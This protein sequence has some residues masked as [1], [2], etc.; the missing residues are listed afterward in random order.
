MNA[1]PQLQM[2]LQPI[3][4]PWFIVLPFPHLQQLGSL[5][6]KECRELLEK[7]YF[8]TIHHI[9]TRSLRLHVSPL[10]STCPLWHFSGVCLSLSHG[11]MRPRSKLLCLYSIRVGLVESSRTTTSYSCP[12]SE[13]TIVYVM[14]LL[15][16][17]NISRCETVCESHAMKPPVGA[18]QNDDGPCVYTRQPSCSPFSVHS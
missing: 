1:V 12:V 13:I 5:Q 15:W 3:T 8:R 17:E 9:D 10:R 7:S 14:L 6:V 16:L 4:G 2:Y 18:A 11:S